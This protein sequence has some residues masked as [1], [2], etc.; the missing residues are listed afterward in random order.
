[1]LS[2]RPKIAELAFQVF[3]R[4]LHPELF[5]TH[6]SRRIQRDA[7]SAELAITNSGHIISWTGAG[8]TI[9]EIACS[10]QQL[11][12]TRRCL[13]KHQLKGSQRDRVECRSGVCY[14]TDFSLETVNVDLFW[15]IQKQL[16]DDTTEGL[17]HRFD[18]SGRIA[19]GAISYI[20]VDTRAKS[21]LV[22]AIHTFPDDHAIVKVESCF[23]LA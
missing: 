14:S 4:S 19:M 23:E 11:L 5:E 3:G 9:S 7:F 20:H 18:S 8:T 10:A 6:R 16:T 21:M 22:Q 2:V 12:P 17:L 15:A 1:M 13:M